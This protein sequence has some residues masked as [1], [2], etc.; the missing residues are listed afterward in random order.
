MTE[1]NIPN[2]MGIPLVDLATDLLPDPTMAALDA[3][4]F[5]SGEGSGAFEWVQTTPLAT[6]TIPVP[7]AMLGR[8]PNVSIYVGNEMVE[9][10]ISSDGIQVVITFPA[11]QIGSA[12]LS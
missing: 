12:V 5:G 10:D 3:R 1:F 4:Y 8:R 9:S 11:P 7:L 2:G 6:W